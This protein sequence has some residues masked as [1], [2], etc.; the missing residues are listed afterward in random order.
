MSRVDSYKEREQGGREG[1]PI[2][3]VD[4]YDTSGAQVCY[5]SFF[6]Y[7]FLLF[8]VFVL[9]TPLSISLP[10]FHFFMQTV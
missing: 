4:L 8:A 5:C 9:F 6:P 3:V 2:P 10:I 7:P 1:S